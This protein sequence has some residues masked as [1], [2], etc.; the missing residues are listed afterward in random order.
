MTASGV[1]QSPRSYTSSA[2]G[3]PL[4]F[5]RDGLNLFQSYTHPAERVQETLD[6]LAVQD[7]ALA[8]ALGQALTAKRMLDVGAGQRLMGMAYYH[9]RGNELVGIDL[10]VIVQ[11]LDPRG[12]VEMARANGTRRVAKTV[13]RKGL[14]VDLRLRREL[15]RRL[16]LRSIPRFDVRRMDACGLAFPDESFD[17]VYSTEVFSFVPDPSSALRETARLLRPGGATDHNFLL[18]T[19]RTGGLDVRMIGGR[20]ADLPLWAHLRPQHA[21]AVLES[22]YLNRVRLSE[23]RD[24][25][26]RHLPGSQVTLFQPE[27]AWLE[28]EAR[29]LQAAGELAEFS[30]EELVTTD[31]SITWRKPD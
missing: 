7:R 2:R 3:G 20:G 11:G 31:V 6:K 22:A 16:G 21:N 10:D 17:V 25:A 4:A 9:A 18:Y 5:L 15:A 27:R 13:A 30:I 23:W 26:E 28:P 1:S 12:Y 24:L 14:L 29:R 8:A 19:A